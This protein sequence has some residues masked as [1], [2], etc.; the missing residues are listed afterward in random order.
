MTPCRNGH[1]V[2]YRFRTA[3][4]HLRCSQCLADARARYIAKTAATDVG[5]AFGLV[6]NALKPLSFAEQRRV[7]RALAV[8]GCAP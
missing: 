2:R 4:G 5:R 1:S 6:V 8:F 7:M 3:Q